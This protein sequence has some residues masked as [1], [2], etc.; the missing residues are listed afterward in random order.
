MSVSQERSDPPVRARMSLVG[1]DGNAF[2][3]LGA[4]RQGLRRAGATPE[5]MK[6]FMD[7]AMS[8][9]YDAL[10]AA[11]MRWTDDSDDRNV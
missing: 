9:D 6:Q 7:E 11:A 8:G 5:Q 10:L 1:I 3:V 2:A 4:V